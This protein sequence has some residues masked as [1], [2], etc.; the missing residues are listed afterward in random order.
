MKA[1]RQICAA[2]TAL[3]LLAACGG[4]TTSPATQLARLELR[5]HT[6]AIA[7]GYFTTIEAVAYDQHNATMATPVLSWS[8]DDPTIATVDARGVVTGQG[9]GEV[10]IRASSGV[11]EGTLRIAVKASRVV[12]RTDA[13]TPVLVIGESVVLESQVLDV[14][15]RVIEK[16]PPLTWVT[17][18]PELVTLDAVPELGPSFVRVTARSTGLASIS[19]GAEGMEN[20]FIVGVIPEPVPADAPLR[21]SSFFFLRYS[22][23]FA[24][25]SPFMAIAVERNVTVTRVEIALPSMVSKGLPPLCSNGRLSAGI[26]ELLSG[27]SYPLAALYTYAHIDVYENYGVALL[28]YRTEEGREIHTVVRGAIDTSI[29][30]SGYVTHFP[31]QLCTS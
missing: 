18:D 2:F 30:D 12:I 19:V 9:I 17:A 25:Y 5:S 8:S 7:V 24:S 21:I 6:R 14:R 4:E 23:D 11:F 28:T 3:A 10:T 13:G 31:W 20:V 27:T 1:P 26:H 15:G 29:R 22:S 16:H